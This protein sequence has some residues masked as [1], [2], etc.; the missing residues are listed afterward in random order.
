MIVHSG[1]VAH[2]SA[3]LRKLV[4]GDMA[5]ATTRVA[6]L[7]DV[8]PGTF[9]R[10]SQ[11][12]YTGDYAAVHAEMLL[13]SSMIG[14]DR[15]DTEEESHDSE[16]DDVPKVAPLEVA[17]PS[18][19]ELFQ[20][21]SPRSPRALRKKP[22]LSWNHQTGWCLSD[23]SH[24]DGGTRARL[25]RP[26][27]SS[28]APTRKAWLE[29]QILS[30]EESSTPVG[31]KAYVNSEPGEDYTEVFLCHARLYVFAEKYDIEPLRRLSKHNM[32]RL[33][34]DFHLYT[35]RV[36]DIVALLR[37]VYGNTPHRAHTRDE[38]RELVMKYIVCQYD[39]MA[40]SEEFLDLMEEGRACVRDCL[41]ML[42][43]IVK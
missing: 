42:S 29:F 26:E 10:F 9:A 25:S 41:S 15:P 23:R 6:T 2:H 32:H 3:V 37:Y 8:D 43:G 13:D 11:W 5:E 14:T 28:M 18:D 27:A 22:Q 19:E 40:P 1:M 24:A 36:G 7:V 16:S 33:L 17:P 35:E 20:D 30:P 34:S 21:F 4:D 12:G 31:L 39:K 38:L